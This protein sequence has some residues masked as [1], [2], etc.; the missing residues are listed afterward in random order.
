MPHT[1]EPILTVTGLVKFYGD[2]EVLRNLSLSLS[3]GEVRALMGVNG[4]GK[5]TLVKIMAGIIEPTGGQMDLAGVPYRPMSPAEARDAG[6]GVVHQELSLVP[7]LTVAENITMGA[8]PVKG[9]RRLGIVDLSAI[10]RRAGAALELLGED[11]SMRDRVGT[12]PPA[13]QQLVEIA[14]A[15]VHEPQVLVLDEPTSSLAAHEVE[16]LLALVRRLAARGVSVVYVSHRMDEIPR[17]ADTVTV[18]RDGRVVETGAIGEMSTRRIAEL[19]VGQELAT[20]HEQAVPSEIGEPLLEVEDLAV[21]GH[22]DDVSFTARAGEVVGIA[23]L[24]GSGRTEILRAVFGLDHS[25]GAVRVHGQLLSRRSPRAMVAAGVGMTPED[26]KGQGLIL[27]LSVSENLAMAS[28]GRLRNRW[29]VLS[30]RRQREMAQR[31][32]RDRAIATHDPD[33]PVGSLSGGNQ[34]KVVIGKWL[35]RDVDVLLM[36]EPTRGVDVHAKQQTY[37][38]ITQFARRGG[39]VVFVSSEVEE[40]FLV[41]HRVLVV[42]GGAVVAERQIGDTNIR[43]ILALSMEED[44]SA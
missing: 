16:N 15:L 32:I 9:P 3:A 17:V 31:S 27:K 12:L 24:M 18:M 6:I 8:W 36:D 43:E 42:R 22:V 34:Q 26:R 39:A 33:L 5:S 10:E 29:R 20:R 11:I 19:M 23:G 28:Y 2:N 38:T 25:T 14:K 37:D 40:L 41:C 35:N 4:A 21:A 30:S 13:K 1:T 7:G 44:T